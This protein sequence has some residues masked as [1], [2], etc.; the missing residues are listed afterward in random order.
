MVKFF[1]VDPGHLRE[2]L[3]RYGTYPCVCCMMLLENHHSPLN[4]EGASSCLLQG[5]AFSHSQEI[6]WNWWR[7]AWLTCWS[8]ES[9]EFQGEVGWC[10]R[11][12]SRA[13][14]PLSG[15]T[16]TCYSNKHALF[17][18]CFC[19]NQHSYDASWFPQTLRRA[20]MRMYLRSRKWSMLT[21]WFFV[22]RKVPC[23]ITIGNCVYENMSSV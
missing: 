20:C 17:P 4:R 10:S 16:I 19:P 6:V 2:E 1:P 9:L 21:W 5:L 14:W 7:E 13:R 15:H 11:R 23:R 3:T 22:H 8:S 18:W 12:A